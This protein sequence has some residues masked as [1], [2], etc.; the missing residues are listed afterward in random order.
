VQALRSERPDARLS[1]SHF[2]RPRRAGRA[3]KILFLAQRVPYP[4]NRGDKITTWRLVER[5]RRSHEVSVV[6]FAHDAADL[7]AAREL[8]ARGIETVAV[9]LR[10]GLARLRA[11]PLLLGSTPITLGV[12]GSRALRA[13][14][15]RR[16]GAVDLVYAYSSSMGAYFP[17][18][19][20][21]PGPRRV[22]HFAELDSDK[23][24][25]Y[26]EHT[27]FPWSALWRREA[28]TLAGFE[29]ALARNAD[30]NVFCT[31]LEEAIFRE[32]IPGAPSMVLRNGIE[33]EAFP[34]APADA[35]PGA[36]VFVGVMDY[37][38]NVEGCSWFVR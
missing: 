12:Y 20:A 37:Y 3:L 31:P 32:R 27:S 38:P 16:A 11:L 28:R 6:A 14:V 24:R 25:Q 26:A 5:M 17:A 4:P 36:L 18:R 19:G 8:G 10:P 33:L 22:M 2:R 34:A 23:W 15:E 1:R 9:R 29:A 30:Q 7:E 35:E 13:E 21:G